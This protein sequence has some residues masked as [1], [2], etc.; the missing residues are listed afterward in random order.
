[1]RKLLASYA[2]KVDSD[3]E[4][5]VL[6]EPNII[7]KPESEVVDELVS[8]QEEFFLPLTETEELINTLVELLVEPIMELVPSLIAILLRSPDIYDSLQIF[9]QETGSQKISLLMIQSAICSV[10]IMDG[11]HLFVTYDWLS[12]PSVTTSLSRKPVSLPLPWFSQMHQCCF[13]G[14]PLGL[15]EDV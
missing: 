10:F 13:S 12:L 14:H 6:I 2:A 1:M 7:D 3:L 11:L 5:P 4:P 9:L 15:I 8:L